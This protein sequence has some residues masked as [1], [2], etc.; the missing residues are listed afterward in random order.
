MDPPRLQPPIVAALVAAIAL[1]TVSVDSRACVDGAP[2]GEAV[3]LTREAGA[4]P[5]GERA[6]LQIL[7]AGWFRA[8]EI[9]KRGGGSD[10]TQVPI[11][12][13]GEPVITTSF[14]TLKNAWNQLTT[15]YIVAEVRSEG[16]VSTMTVW[17]KP[18]LKFRALAVVRVEV[19]EEGVESVSLRAVMNKP[20]PHEHVPGQ[21]GTA[22]ALPA[23]K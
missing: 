9:V 7:G 3:T 20:G 5:A 23:F 8:V 1:G 14:A 6:G 10:R 22:V 18:E 15:D 19:E 17:Y 16:Q 13:D 21:P 12:L 4:T 11:E 2:L